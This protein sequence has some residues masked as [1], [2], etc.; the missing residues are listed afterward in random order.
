MS[1]TG[2]FICR[3]LEFVAEDPAIFNL[4]VIDNV[5]LARPDATEQE[6]KEACRLAYMDEFIDKLPDR[7]GTMIGERGVQLS[8]GQRQRLALARVILSKAGIIVLDEATSMLD[9]ESETQINQTLDWLADERTFI[10]IAHRF[11]SVK[12]SDRIMLMDNG[13][14][15]DEGSHE[16]QWQR[17]ETYRTL[18]RR[19]G[20]GFIRT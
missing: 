2:S 12:P 8:G 10:V 3:I 19:P 16:E 14:L 15:M 4:S 13:C 20:S 5:R 17:N 7:Y 11:S 1:F 9:H 18:F 6:I